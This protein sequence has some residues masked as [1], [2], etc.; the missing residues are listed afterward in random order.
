MQPDGE[1]A[2]T[3]EPLPPPRR[4]SRNCILLIIAGGV[5][6]FLGCGVLM[7]IS[8]ANI[9]DDVAEIGNVFSEAV[10]DRNQQAGVLNSFMEAMAARDTIKAR[11]YI[12]AQSNLRLSNMLDQMTTGADYAMFNHYQNLVLETSPFDS[13]LG[14]DDELA[15]IPVSGS[16][17][18]SDGY[19]GTFEAQMVKQGAEW[20]IISIEIS[21][22]PRKVE[23]ELMPQE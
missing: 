1:Y 8:F 21:V 12:A 15:V 9:F 3:P 5:L 7:A 13:S 16:V 23:Q 4:S 19:K 6:S 10:E 11:T 17:L 22:P 14:S 20:V 18:Y 2:F